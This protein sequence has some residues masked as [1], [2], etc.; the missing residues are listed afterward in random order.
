M[1]GRS[2]PRKNCS[3]ILLILQKSGINS[4]V[5]VKVVL[6]TISQGFTTIQPVV[7]FLGISGCHQQDW[8]LP[9]HPKHHASSSSKGCSLSRTILGRFLQIEHSFRGRLALQFGDLSQNLA[10]MKVLF[11]IWMGAKFQAAAMESKHPPC[12]QTILI[13]IHPPLQEIAALSHLSS[14]KRRSS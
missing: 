12:S 13:T 4:P 3:M 6:P 14:R 9:K 1:L 11:T 7:V 5:E 2:R 10:L 8:S